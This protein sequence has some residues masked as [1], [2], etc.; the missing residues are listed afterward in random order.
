MS[1]RQIIGPD[2]E[3][4]DLDVDK[5]R[6]Y[7]DETFTYLREEANAKAGFKESV[8]TIAETTG[9]TKGFVSKY[10]KAAFKAETKKATKLGEAFESVDEAINQ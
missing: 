10:L 2:G 6:A 4:V 1:I 9:L 3:Q 5:F 7:R 8:E